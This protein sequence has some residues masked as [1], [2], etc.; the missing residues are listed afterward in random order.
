MTQGNWLGLLARHCSRNNPP[1]WDD[2]LVGYDFSILDL[3][4]IQAWVRAQNLPGVACAA[5]VALDGEGLLAFETA[6]WAAVTEATGQTPRPGGRRWARAQDR[7][8]VA[9]LKEAVA[10]PVSAEALA[11]LVEAVYDTLGCPE[12]MLD[13]WQRH[14]G[15]ERREGAADRAKVLEFIRRRELELVAAQ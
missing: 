9:L 10:A 12:D 6:L 1:G 13:L 4:E 2:L 5:L 14:A 3:E 11:V 7:W 15:W 8:R